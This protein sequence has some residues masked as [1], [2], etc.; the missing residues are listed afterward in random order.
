MFSWI[1]SHH[2]IFNKILCIL[3]IL[4]LL[5]SGCSQFYKSVVEQP[6]PTA[7]IPATP[8]TTSSTKTAPF[9]VFDVQSGHGKGKWHNKPE[10][11][12]R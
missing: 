10:D 5:G 9:G 12:L 2:V 3:G 4:V 7:T 6:N 11:I 8:N 1:R